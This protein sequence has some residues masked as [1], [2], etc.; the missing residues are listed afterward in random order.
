LIQLDAIRQPDR[1]KEFL[2][3]CEADSRGR[4]GLENSPMPAADLLKIAL[5]AASSVD[6]GV[7]AKLHSDTESIKA[8]VFEARLQAIQQVLRH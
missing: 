8:A 3:A 1:F 4:K 2:R 5:E 7:V 6:A